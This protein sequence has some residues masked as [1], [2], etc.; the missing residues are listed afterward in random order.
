MEVVIAVIVG[1]LIGMPIGIFIMNRKLHK[2]SNGF[3]MF[4]RDE[5]KLA[6]YLCFESLDD[7]TEIQKKKFVTLVVSWNKN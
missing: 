6:P 1:I 2:K 3:L 7:L 5:P 4:D